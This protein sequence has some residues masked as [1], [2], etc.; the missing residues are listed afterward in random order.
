MKTNAHKKSASKMLKYIITF[1]DLV[2]MASIYYKNTINTEKRY[3]AT[4]IFTELVITNKKLANIKAK[5]DFGVLFK[6]H[7]LI[8]C[9]PDYLFTELFD[10]FPVVKI[11][12]N[13]LK[14]LKLNYLRVT[15]CNFF[16]FYI[17]NIK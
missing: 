10:I 16:I 14:T 2:K 5:E 11:S 13:K 17:Y 12:L 3:I 1:S 9:S 8:S 7:D 4:N 6:R 15:N